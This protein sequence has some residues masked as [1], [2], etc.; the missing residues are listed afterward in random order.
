MWGGKA[1]SEEPVGVEEGIADRQQS[2]PNG[3]ELSLLVS[4]SNPPTQKSSE[5]VGGPWP[6]FCCTH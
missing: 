4:N 2:E 1:L 3:Q 6:E 5:A